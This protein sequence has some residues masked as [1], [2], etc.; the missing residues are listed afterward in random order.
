MRRRAFEPECRPSR[1][2]ARTLSSCSVAGSM[3]STPRRAA[4]VRWA[5]GTL[6][7][8]GGANLRGACTL[9]LQPCRPRTAV[10]ASAR[11]GRG[12]AL[13]DVVRGGGDASGKAVRWLCSW[14][15]TRGAPL[16]GIHSP[17]ALSD[18]KATRQRKH[19]RA[20][21]MHHHNATRAMRFRVGFGKRRERTPRRAPRA[22]SHV[23]AHAAAH[24]RTTART[25]AQLRETTRNT[26]DAGA[27]P[28]A[29]SPYRAARGGRRRQPPP[30]R[31]SP[32]PTRRR[33]PPSVPCA[34]P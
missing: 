31:P 19:N 8:D 32:S 6:A 34:P 18:T 3:A 21:A 23:T 25:H 33:A 29:V 2:R 1:P 13:G 11:A 17:S 15:V 4:K 16:L 9:L 10:V 27:A 26:N 30:R 14:V 7:G 24:G 20:T 22:S 12:G 5:G 28:R